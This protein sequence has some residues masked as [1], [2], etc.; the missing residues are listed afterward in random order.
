MRRP[1]FIIIITAAALVA[2]LAVAA[3]AAQAGNYGGF[4]PKA[5]Y[6]GHK[7]PVTFTVGKSGKQ[8]YRFRWTAFGCFGAGGPGNPFINNPWLVK[9]VGTIKI[10][11]NGKFS[12][13]NVK[14]TA[15]AAGPNQP[16]TTT[17]STVSGRFVTAKTVVGTITYHQSTMAGMPQSL[18]TCSGTA[19]NTPPLKF[20]AATR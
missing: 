20:Y 12:I 3:L 11:S 8:I 7:A 17:W 15:K 1:I 2:L 13:K 14:W 18:H 16:A 4:I 19:H 6:N 5:A 10:L 9:R